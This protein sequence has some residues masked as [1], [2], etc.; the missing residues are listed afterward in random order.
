[1]LT[2]ELREYVECPDRF[3]P[4]IPGASV[5][6]TMDDRVCVIQG[7][8][9]AAVS[10]VNVA[11]HEV[12]ALL[13]E[14]R[15]RIPP[16]KSQTWWLGPSTQPTDLHERLVAL[17]LTEADPPLLHG[18]ALTEP[19]G[20]PPPDVEVHR[21]ETLED[22][23]ASR[24]VQW[25]AFGTPEQ[26]RADNRAR[27]REDFEESMRFEVPI[28]FLATL[29]GKP[30]ATAMAIPSERG[31]LLIGGS[32]ASWARGRGLYRALVRARWDL[33]VARGTPALVVEAIPDTS[34]PILLGLGF[35][36]VCTIRRLEDRRV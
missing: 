16:E 33:A 31:V 12:E 10:G 13:A 28:T 20:E 22:F 25:D 32:T 4:I 34:Y 17:G 19:P 1:M 24:E 23:A 36:E 26:K 6:R 9:W 21:V 5:T 2:P 27:N 11:G 29:E 15:E 7:P 8:L 18:L 14:V 35:E 3:A 30:A